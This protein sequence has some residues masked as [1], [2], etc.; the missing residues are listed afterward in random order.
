MSKMWQEQAVVKSD[1]CHTVIDEDVDGSQSSFGL[2]HHAQH[3]RFTGHISDT[4]HCTLTRAATAGGSTQSGHHTFGG[5]TVR[6][7]DC[8]AC[9]SSAEAL[10]NG[11]THR[12]CTTT[13]EC[14]AAIQ[15]EERLRVSREISANGKWGN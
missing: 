2:L 15:S 13:D 4:R 5:R 1:G 11:F 12:L 10:G 6:I 7:E 8:N 14:H 3:I 9:T